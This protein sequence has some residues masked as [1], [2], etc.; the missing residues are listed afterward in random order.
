MCALSLSFPARPLLLRDRAARRTP[1]PHPLASQACF[2]LRNDTSLRYG[3]MHP[4]DTFNT[5]SAFKAG[6]LPPND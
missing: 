1:P 6:P 4:Y 5:H 2:I 3:L